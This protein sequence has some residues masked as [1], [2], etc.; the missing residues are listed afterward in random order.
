MAVVAG[1]TQP[2]EVLARTHIEVPADEVVPGD[3]VRDQGIFRQVARIEPRL[4]DLA[5]VWFFDPIEGFEDQL[6]VPSLVSV[7][8]WRVSG[9]E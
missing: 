5:L 9:D 6:A 8:V 7:S 1:S 3:V 2:L 4:V